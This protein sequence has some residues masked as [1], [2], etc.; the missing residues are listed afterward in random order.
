HGPADRSHDRRGRGRGARHDG[1]RE[2][3]RGLRRPPPHGEDAGPRV[4]P[5]HRRDADGRRVRPPRAQGGPLLRHGLRARRRDADT[6]GRPPRTARA[7]AAA[8]REGKR[9]LSR[10]SLTSMFG[11]APELRAVIEAVVEGRVGRATHEGPAARLSVGCY[12][13]FGGDPA[14]AGA[15]VLV[16]SAARPRELVYGHDPARRPG[17]LQVPRGPALDPPRPGLGPSG[18]HPAALDRFEAA[19]PEDFELR[20][21]DPDLAGQLDADLE[22]HALQVFASAADFL[23]RGLGV[24][25]VR[26]GQLAC[27]ATSYTRS[28]HS[29]EVAIA[30]RAA[31]P[32]PA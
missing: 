15:R 30:T 5:R 20:A 22:P 16:A 10:P 29:V 4:P 1:V 23:E 8:V 2:A 13:I 11:R 18:L 32:G 28:S 31:F 7:P 26:E 6:Q 24:A 14:S 27:A 19:L 21:F 12:E 3:N 9:I 25:A 17:I